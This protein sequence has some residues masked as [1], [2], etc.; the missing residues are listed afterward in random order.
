MTA[1]HR[2]FAAGCAVLL[3]L[4]LAP[5]HAAS[6]VPR[7]APDFTIVEPSGRTT[8]LSSFKGQV[9]L[10]EF[11]FVKCQRC[12]A[13]AQTIDKLYAELGPRG[14]QPVALAF[15]NGLDSGQMD[16]FR[17]LLKIDYLF[18][19]TTAAAVDHYLGRAPMER[20]QLP[21]MVLIDRAG[22][23]RTQSLPIGE[24]KMLGEASL[25]QMIEQLLDEA[26]PSGKSG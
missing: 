11:M 2:M 24:T 5:V 22:V 9:V 10:L 23:I 21:Q 20:F 6:P 25:R 14:F 19:A 15:D 13:A 16:V 26:A 17:K 18:G 1:I 12:T 4:C 7:D 3:A 8:S